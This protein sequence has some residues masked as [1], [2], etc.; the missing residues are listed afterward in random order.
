MNQPGEMASVKRPK[1]KWRCEYGFCS[2]ACL[3]LGLIAFNYDFA[4]A[5]PDT[6]AELPG[7]LKRVFDLSEIFAHGFGIFLVVVGIWTLVPEKRRFLPRLISCAVIPS[8]TVQLVKLLVARR[9]PTA[10]L[11]RDGSVEFPER[12]FDTWLGWLP[13]QELNLKYISQSFPSAHTATAI[14]MAVGLSWM[15]PRGKILFFTIAFLS[16]SQR[17]TS[18]AHWSSDV[19][20]GAAIA[21][22]MAGALT[23]N[24]GWGY[25]V[26]RLE[27]RHGNQLAIGGTKP[28]LEQR[29]RAA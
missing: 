5:Q 27:R 2:L 14:G 12:I 15:F 4:F 20:F 13:Q 24:W 16:A 29:T 6:M 19:F 23:Q 8:L 18:L 11:N 25:V 3:C 26:G 28:D 10:F 17:I 21:F 9:R 1:T 22:V 7:D